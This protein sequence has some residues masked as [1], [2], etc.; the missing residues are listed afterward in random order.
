MWDKFNVASYKIPSY[1]NSGF[2]IDIKNNW[3]INTEKNYKIKLPFKVNTK[4]E[5]YYFELLT[6]NSFVTLTLIINI[7]LISALLDLSRSYNI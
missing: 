2:S 1:F 4:N 3:I 5:I 7:D 6:T